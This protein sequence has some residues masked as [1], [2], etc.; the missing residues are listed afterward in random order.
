MSQAGT[1]A[2][3]DAV[4]RAGDHSP[5]L[6]EALLARREIA[7]TFLTRGANSA[8]QL[9][10]ARADDALDVRLR[11]QRYGLALAVALGD[12]AGE[13]PLE[14]VTRLLSDFADKAI[15]EAVAAAIAERVPSAEPQ[16]FAVIAMGKLG[17][18]ELNYSSDV[19]LLLLFDPDTLPKR[20]RD[21]AGETAVRYGR[22][23][24][25]LLQKR[26]GDGYG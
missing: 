22:R 15:D 1:E 16:G 14:Q 17:S 5:F 4:R 20:A 13:L 6:R 19:D 8:A 12:L 25:E 7:D 18:R 23:L 21:D 24:I 3:A 2:R 9:A 10:L 26:T 11:R